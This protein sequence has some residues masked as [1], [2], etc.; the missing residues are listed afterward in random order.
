[1]SLDSVKSKIDELLRSLSVRLQQDASLVPVISKLSQ[2]QEAI[3]RADLKAIRQSSD[4]LE[5]VRKVDEILSLIEMRS[6]MHA[7]TYIDDFIS[8]QPLLKYPSKIPGTLFESEKT[9]KVVVDPKI[10]GMKSPDQV[11][12]DQMMSMLFPGLLTFRYKKLRKVPVGRWSPFKF[13]VAPPVSAV[14][15]TDRDSFDVQKDLLPPDYPA[16][17]STVT[18][19]IPLELNLSEISQDFVR[20]EEQLEEKADEPAEAESNL[21]LQLCTRCGAVQDGDENCG[22]GREFFRYASPPKSYSLIWNIVD[23][24]KNEAVRRDPFFGQIFSEASFSSDT[25]V[26]KIL[27]GFERKFKA[28]S[29]RIHYDTLYG[30]A[31]KTDGIR[32]RVSG[33]IVKDV[34][35]HI[36]HKDSLLLRDLRILQ[37][38]QEL[39]RSIMRNKYDFTFSQSLIIVKALILEALMRGTPRTSEEVDVVFENARKQPQKLL[40]G[41]ELLRKVIDVSMPLTEKDLAHMCEVCV[42]EASNAVKLDESVERFVLDVFSHSLEHYVLTSAMILLGVDENDIRSH[43]TQNKDELYLYDN[44]PDGNGCSETLRKFAKVTSSQ[45]VSAVRDALEKD[46][47]VTLPSKD[48]FSILE[49]FLIGCKAERADSI[50]MK[51]IRD[52]QAAKTIQVSATE[53]KIRQDLLLK[54]KEDFAFDEYTI[55]HLDA[56]FRTE[57][58][59]HVLKN[60]GDE[61]LFV[62]KLVP[63]ALVLK[64]PENDKFRIC[65]DTA[66]EL[67]RA[68]LGKVQDALE[69]CI[70]G[71]PLCLYGSYCEMSIFLMKYFLSRRLVETGYKIV[72]DRF[73]VDLETLSREKLLE[74]ATEMLNSNKVLYLRA[75]ATNVSLLMETAFGLLGQPA[76]DSKAYMKMIS[77]DLMREGYVVKLEAD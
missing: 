27:Y 43:H 10:P 63:E 56:L 66:V 65:P 25:S 76:A 55:S 42:S 37:Y 71:C 45:R 4:E 5:R 33:K 28:T 1:M 44:L 46:M 15:V 64:L 11:S 12:V 60:L 2:L 38:I 47:P 41:L 50:Y 31:F 8:M 52:P 61:D 73:Y 70:D 36:R 49:E 21:Y 3:S 13:R 23:S 77:F 17:S 51:L 24:T 32:F 26:K 53:D 35:E 48:F 19:H 67:D 74:I 18:V 29:W 54:L 20:R 62:F 22:C 58:H 7:P 68:V 75:S 34:V 57:S 14:F 69:M 72:R 16:E 6:K 39:H 9:R 30:D 40:E 59:F